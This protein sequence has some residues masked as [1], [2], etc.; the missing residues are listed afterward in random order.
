MRLNNYTLNIGISDGPE[1]NEDAFYE[2]TIKA[3]PEF[4]SELMPKTFLDLAHT[5]TNTLTKKDKKN[6]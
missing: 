6:G 5:L 1:Y 3:T 2:I 4:G